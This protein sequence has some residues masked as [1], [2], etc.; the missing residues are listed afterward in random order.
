MAVIS[1]RAK[2]KLMKEEYMELKEGLVDED[3]N[4]K[5]VWRS[6]AL[7]ADDIYRLISYNSGKTILI[8][9]FDDRLLVEEPFDQLLKKWN[10]NK[11]AD[12]DLGS[13]ET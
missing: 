8:D 3:K 11:S 9:A 1:I 12:L 6:V 4:T 10:D 2:V 13:S 7:E 5:W